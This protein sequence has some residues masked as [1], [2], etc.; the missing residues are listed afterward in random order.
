MGRAI[1]K[2]VVQYKCLKSK[3]FRNKALFCAAVDDYIEVMAGELEV[4]LVLQN[5]FVVEKRGVGRS[6]PGK[7]KGLDDCVY[8]PIVDTH[9]FHMSTL[10]TMMRF[11]EAVDR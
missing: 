10:Y 4:T 11:A 1:N 2:V 9:G 7:M 8:T 3:M 6:Y 5:T